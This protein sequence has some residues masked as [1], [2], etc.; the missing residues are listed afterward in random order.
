MLQSFTRISFATI[1]ASWLLFVLSFFLPATN[2]LGKAGT[3]PDVPLTGWQA[4]TTSIFCGAMNPWMWIA[5]PRVVLFLIFPFANSLML[6]APLMSIMLREK[7]AALAIFIVPC[8]VVPWCMPKKL[9]GDLFVGFYCWNGSFF[10]MS[11]GCI[12]A[13]LAYD[14]VDNQESEPRIN[15]NQR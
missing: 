7:A 6:I 14:A 10:A 3:L 8:A 1:V 13:S 9:L 5:E 2:I 11:L 12:L 15:A 4:F